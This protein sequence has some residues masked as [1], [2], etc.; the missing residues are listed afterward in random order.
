VVE[1][2]DQLIPGGDPDIVR[3]LARRIGG[4]YQNVYL[5]TRLTSVEAG[6]DGLRVSFEGPSAPGSDMFDQILMAVGRVPSGRLIGAEA[7]RVLVDDRGYI[8]VNKA[9]AHQRS[10]HLRHRRHRRAA[11]ARPQGH[12]RGRVA[13]EAAVGQPSYFDAT[14]M[15]SVAYTHPAVAWAGLTET[16]AKA[17]GTAYGKGVFPWAASGRA[18]S[19]GRD[20]GLTKL[21]FAESTGR[22]VGAGITGPNAG[23]LIAEIAHAIEMGRQRRR[24][25]AHHPP[26]PHALGDHRPG[27]RGV[28][29]HHHRPVPAE[30]RQARSHWRLSCLVRSS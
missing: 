2:M 26:A 20:E 29:G 19:L 8:R 12:P 7:A 24:H 4:Q 3:P 23:E 15:P 27:G 16:E 28:R 17:A 10:A 6:D 5:R 25:R 13:A 11:D 14:V 21:L 9:A 22:L 18:L 30:K 1:L